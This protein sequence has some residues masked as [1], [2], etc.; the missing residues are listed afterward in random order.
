MFQITF[1]ISD[2]YLRFFLRHIL[3]HAKLNDELL[4]I[5]FSQ[6]ILNTANISRRK[7]RCNIQAGYAL[8]MWT[9][10]NLSSYVLSRAIRTHFAFSLSTVQTKVCE[11]TSSDLNIY[12]DVHRRVLS[13]TYISFIQLDKCVRN[14]SGSRTIPSERSAIRLFKCLASDFPESIPRD[15]SISREPDIVNSFLHHFILHPVIIA[16]FASKF[17]KEY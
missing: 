16:R 5:Y 2:F 10:V 11:L 12:T 13:S 9:I 14:K 6:Q 15:I 17:T 8:S 3:Q 1:K 4:Q 7:S